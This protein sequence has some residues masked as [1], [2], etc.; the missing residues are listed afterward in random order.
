MLLPVETG[1]FHPKNS[2]NFGRIP[3]LPIAS[4][5]GTGRRMNSARALSILTRGTG[6]P[7]LCCVLSAQIAIR[8]TTPVV[9]EG[10]TVKFTVNDS[11]TWS[12]APGSPG[13]L[14]ADGTYHAPSQIRAKAVVGG[15]QVLPND[16]VYNT[17]IDA[18]PPDPH[19]T[20]WIAIAPNPV[21]LFAGGAFPLNLY[22]NAAPQLPQ[23]FNY[24]PKNDGNYFMPP[25][26][27]L[28]I[29]HGSHTYDMLGQDRHM[30]SIDHGNCTA[31]EIYGPYP[32]GMAV[33]CP[34]C[35][36]QSGVQWNMLDYAIPPA[37]TDAAS[38]Q[39]LPLTYRRDEIVSGN[40]RHAGRFTLAVGYIA[41]R[42]I[43]WPAQATTGG[44]TP[45]KTMPMGA[46]VRLKSGFPIDSLKSPYARNLALAFARY[47]LILADVGTSWNVASET[48]VYDPDLEAAFQEIRARL[49]NTDFEVVDESSL[50]TGQTSG[51]VNPANGHVDPGS[52]IV[53]ATDARGKKGTTHVILA[54]PAVGVDSPWMAIQAGSAPV[55]LKAWVNGLEN[56]ALAW[57]MQPALGSLSESGVYRPPASATA[58]SS[59]T[60]TVTSRADAAIAASIGISVLPGGAIRINSGANADYTDGKG[61]IW[62]GDMVRG[63]PYIGMEQ[64]WKYDYSHGYTWK[65]TATPNL[66]NEWFVGEDVVY[67]LTVPNGNYKVT[68]KL[69]EVHLAKV[70]QRCSDIES[71][72][73]V[74]YHGWD[75]IAEAGAPDTAIDV[76]LPAKVTDGTLS[77]AMRDKGCSR[78]PVDFWTVPGYEQDFIP[79]LAAVQIDPDA[80]LPHISFAGP[81]SVVTTGQEVKL[82]ALRWYFGG[83]LKWTIV[84]GPG[85]IDDDGVYRAPRTPQNT[86]VTIQVQSVEQP[87]LTATASFRLVFG[88]MVAAPATGFVVHSLSR[89]MSV[90]IGKVPYQNVTWRASLG[91]IRED[92]L[93][94][95]PTSVPQ[96]TSVEITATSK[97]DPTRSVTAKLTV[98]ATLPP[99]RIN[100]GHAQALRDAAGNLWAADPGPSGGDRTTAYGDRRPI[101]NAPA[102]LQGVYQTARY[103]TGRFW[104][105]YRVPNG[106]YRVTLK[107]ADYAGHPPGVYGFSVLL[108]GVKVLS[109]FDI[110][111]AAGGP[112]TAIDKVFTVEVKDSLFKLELASDDGKAAQINGLEL[113]EAVPAQ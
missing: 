20:E 2:E 87:S 78:H 73:Q 38:L 112:L 14:D 104:Y 107:F 96:N 54:A 35:T 84:H 94:T 75:T 98:L 103:N 91:T 53:I 80:S 89:Q 43:R 27:K 22:A 72:G 68:L 23:H 48:S 19:S 33:S 76:E 101:A 95:A 30:I 45:G 71:Q 46:R 61:N 86:Q 32:R 81:P 93:Y 31:Q 65:N 12:L 77:F 40:I 57:S 34:A 3:H 9:T 39:L 24:T 18:L 6:F 8:P 79:G 64:G 11:V 41:A 109:R 102:D 15:C 17:R 42:E 21:V 50:M 28:R 113:E 111:A 52:A 25:P 13:T 66:F 62:Y 108:N 26:E 49:R 55:Q 63:R 36:A 67:R 16:H 7:I 106:T 44:G 97:D 4:R 56:K 1:T 60:V 37:G 5:F 47:G 100:F 90:L 29:E 69:A 59:T 110:V 70:G 85:S 58:L 83:N 88:D 82:T 51:I 92:G 99:F 105:A 10:G 74:I